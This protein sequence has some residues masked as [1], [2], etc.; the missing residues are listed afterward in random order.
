VLKHLAEGAR[1]AIAHFKPEDEVAV[2]V[3]SGG[4]TRW[5]TTSPGTGTGPFKVLG[6]PPA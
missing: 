5:W 3:Y 2:M 1:S 6:R 4:A